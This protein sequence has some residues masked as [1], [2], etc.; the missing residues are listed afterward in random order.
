MAKVDGSP[1]GAAEE[2]LQ[3]LFD[4]AYEDGFERA[5]VDGLWK[6]LVVVLA[7]PMPDPTA[8]AGGSTSG[9]LSTAGVKGAL[10]LIVGGV[11]AAGVVAGVHAGIATSQR[12]PVPS[13]AAPSIAFPLSPSPPSA[14]HASPELPAIP[15]IAPPLPEIGSNAPAERPRATPLSK[16]P[17]ARHATAAA[18]PDSA[19]TPSTQVVMGKNA[20]APDTT[21]RPTAPTP[22][23]DT[24]PAHVDAPASDPGPGEGA[25]LLRARR[26]LASDPTTAFALTEED[27]RRYPR[28]DLAMER[29]V[30]AVESLAALGRHSEARVRLDAFEQRYP[31]SLP[32]AR[33]ERLLSQ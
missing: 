15:V 2:D 14:T 9:W 18:T 23:T 25:L 16:T 3:G 10:A 11:V 13:S 24:A 4:K 20:S 12:T 19:P 5:E 21:S 33:L 27:A 30:L 6:R 32:I 29:E 22:T 31:G 1:P 26:A 7:T 28:G 17:T 8:G